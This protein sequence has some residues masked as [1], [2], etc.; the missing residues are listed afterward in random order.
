MLIYME[1]PHKVVVAVAMKITACWDARTHVPAK[2][3]RLFIDTSA[4]ISKVK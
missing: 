2:I 4:S 1:F 3:H